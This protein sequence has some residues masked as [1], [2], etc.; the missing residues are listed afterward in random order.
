VWV[1]TPRAHEDG[2][3]DKIID[4]VLAFPHP[5]TTEAIQ[6]TID[7]LLAHETADR[8]A[9]VRV[10]TLVLAGGLDLIAPPRY[11]RQVAERIAGAQFEVLPEEAHQ[12][13]QEVPEQFNARVDAFWGG[14][15]RG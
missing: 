3:V 13:F 4:E 15:G 14:A 9:A 6:R 8:L 7:A 11:G 5:P 10:P 1:Y 12:P 2:T